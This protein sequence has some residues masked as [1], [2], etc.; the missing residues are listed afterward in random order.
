VPPAPIIKA[1]AKTK[2]KNEKC[3]LLRRL[4]GILEIWS[5]GVRNGVQGSISFLGRMGLEKLIF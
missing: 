2:S 4:G 5:P 1:K 3:G